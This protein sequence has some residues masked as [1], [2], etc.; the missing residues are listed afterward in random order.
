MRNIAIVG[1][2]ASGLFAAL[3]A[4]YEAKSREIECRIELFEG[5]EKVGKKLAITG[6]SMC[7][8]TNS[9]PF[10]KMVKRYH[11]KETQIRQILSSYSVNE[12]KKIFTS[13]NVPL[14]TREDGKIFPASFK[15]SD[16]ISSL[17]KECQKHHIIISKGRR[18]TSVAKEKEGF[19]LYCNEQCYSYYDALIIAT[20]GLTYPH[21]GSRGDGYRFAQQLGHTIENLKVGLTKVKVADE[22]L[23]SLSG[24]TLEKVSIQCKGE[25]KKEGPLL[26]T[27]DGLSGPV[28]INNS[29]N[30]PLQGKV[31][32]NYINMSSKE[33]QQKI[34]TLC[35]EHGSKMFISILHT[36][37]LPSAFIDYLVEKTNIEGRRKAAEIGKKSIIAIAKALTQDSFEISCKNLEKSAMITRGGV[38]VEE[39]SLETMESKLTPSLYFCGEVVDIDGETGGYNLQYAFSSGAIAGKSCI[40]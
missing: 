31:T 19:S 7:N 11:D 6:S 22:R 18:I 15:S 25:E 13:L 1:G 37:P 14:V 20:G 5:E 28:I 38:S 8:I 12:T 23:N 34:T 29:R 21:T 27:H 36:F 4:A 16:V 17:L 9:E 39:I 24:L 26:I 35:N 3:H 32:I 33:A 30:F 40:K 10:E 2:G